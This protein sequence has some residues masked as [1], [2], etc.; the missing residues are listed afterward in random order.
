MQDLNFYFKAKLQ[1]RR[2]S[3]QNPVY[4]LFLQWRYVR[5]YTPLKPTW[6]AGDTWWYKKMTDGTF[7]SFYHMENLTTGISASLWLPGLVCLLLSWLKWVKKPTAPEQFWF[8][9]SRPQYNGPVFAFSKTKEK[10]LNNILC[11]IIK[12][13][14]NVFIKIG[15]MFNIPSLE[16]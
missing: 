12:T 1:D 15:S 6:A 11:W 10:C 3:Y 4:S 2:I 16:F 9:I 8:L 5:A 14:A 7:K 13:D